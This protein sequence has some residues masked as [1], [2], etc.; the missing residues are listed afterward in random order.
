MELERAAP[1]KE[2]IEKTEM[3]QLTGITIVPAVF[4]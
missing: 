3:V 2:S 4:F 1:S